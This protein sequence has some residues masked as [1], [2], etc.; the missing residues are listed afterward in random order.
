[1]LQFAVARVVAVK[2]VLVTAVVMCAVMRRDLNVM[3][4][5]QA[6]RRMRWSA[7]VV[8]LVASERIEQK[9]PRCF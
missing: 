3:G 6:G 9:V 2:G 4:R 8:G 7:I 1:M 5:N